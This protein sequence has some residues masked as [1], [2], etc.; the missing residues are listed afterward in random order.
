M[1]ATMIHGTRDVRLEAV[2]DPRVLRPTDAL[3]RVSASCVCGSDLWPYRGINPVESP[4]PI[5]HEFVGI[6]EEVGADV[7]TVRPGQFVIA[8]FVYSCGECAHCRYG[9]HTSC[10]RGG[11]GWGGP[12]GDGEPTPACQGEM[13]RVPYADGTLVPTPEVPGEGQLA[14]MLALSD[15]MGTG[16]HCAVSA[17]V[18]EGETVVVVGDG[19]VGLSAVL[20]AARLGAGRVI[21]MSRHETRQA[22]AREFGATDVVAERGEEG[23]ERVLELT[24]GVGADR[25]LECVGTG[26]SMTQAFACAR[27]GGSVGFVGVPHGVE[28]PVSDM[29]RRNVRLAGGV[30]PVRRYLPRLRD[31]VLAGEIDPGRVFDLTLPLAEV[32]EAYAAMDERRAIKVMLRP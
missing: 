11:R 2:A 22:V 15:V 17:G 30:A 20:S 31:E 12:D 6:V 16:W 18:Q 32:A 19:A 1:R 10:V 3:V 7:R 9:V 26:D 27:P 5:G 28:V 21:A 14:S 13:V 8:P 4:R 29:F 24:D 25:V 23:A